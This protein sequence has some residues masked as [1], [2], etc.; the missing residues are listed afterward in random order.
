MRLSSAGLKKGF[1][2]IDRFLHILNTISQPQAYGSPTVT[3][4]LC[5]MII[6]LNH[7]S[8]Y[9]S[10][11]TQARVAESLT[12]LGTKSTARDLGSA[13]VKSLTKR[14]LEIKNQAPKPGQILQGLILKIRHS[15]NTPYQLVVRLKLGPLSVRYQENSSQPQRCSAIA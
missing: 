14:S 6:A 4:A 9:L 3:S 5:Y 15:S 8:A 7:I 12:D 2:Q 11:R 1:F 13:Q 10:N